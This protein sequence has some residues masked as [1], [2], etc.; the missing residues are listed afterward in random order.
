MFGFSSISETPFAALPRQDPN[1]TVIVTG[2]SASAVVGDVI[3]EIQYPVP[4]TGVYAT[5]IVGAVNVWGPIIIVQ[6]G[7]W[8]PVNDS[9]VGAWTPVNTTQ[10]PNWGDVVT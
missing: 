2:V 8:V 10:S 5:G 9:Q 4:V 6:P 3:T 1:V 7:N